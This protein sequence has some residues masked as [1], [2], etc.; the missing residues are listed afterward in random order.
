MFQHS[1]AALLDKLFKMWV[2]IRRSFAFSLRET[3]VEMKSQTTI[4]NWSLNFIRC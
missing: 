4:N 2:F 1:N 3:L